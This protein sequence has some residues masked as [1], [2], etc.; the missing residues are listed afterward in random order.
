MARKRTGKPVGSPPK[1]PYSKNVEPINARVTAELKDALVDA[2]KRSGY[3]LSQ[4]I[5]LRLDHSFT[6]YN[7]D[8]AEFGS[9]Q[10]LAVCRLIGMMMRNYHAF[11]GEELWNNEETHTEL[12]DAVVTI[13]GAFGPN[14]G[15]PEPRKGEAAGQR[16]GRS[17]LVQ[18][19]KNKTLPEPMKIDGETMERL[20]D[21][22]SLEEIWKGLGSLNKKLE[23]KK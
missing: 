6:Y 20:S 8:L 3:S 1:G 2:Q 5:A 23:V 17:R 16:R 18:L 11:E 15:I 7:L 4:E 13:L 21:D 22:Y 10:N 9:L 14:G 12:V 19:A